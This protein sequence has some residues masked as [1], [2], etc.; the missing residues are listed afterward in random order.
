M[1]EAIAEHEQVCSLI[2]PVFAT[3]RNAFCAAPRATRADCLDH[4]KPFFLPL[5]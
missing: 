2:R 1:W 3:T 4:A 5:K